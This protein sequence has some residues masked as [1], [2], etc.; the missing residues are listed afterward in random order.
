M[1]H[2]EKTMA[3]ADHNTTILR[4]KVENSARNIA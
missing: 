2:P 4:M 1:P 3:I